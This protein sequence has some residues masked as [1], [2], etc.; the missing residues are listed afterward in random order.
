MNNIAPPTSGDD[1]PDARSG[2]EEESAHQSLGERPLGEPEASSARAASS[3]WFGMGWRILQSPLTN[4]VAPVITVLFIL[5]AAAIIRETFRDV[6]VIR[7]IGVP[8]SLADNG[9]TS[10]IV[11]QRLLDQIALINRQNEIASR[12]FLKKSR[13][14]YT[15]L[16]E[17]DM[18]LPGLG[19]S[20]RSVLSYLRSTVGESETEI[21]GEIIEQD[22]KR[23]VLRLRVSSQGGPFSD[24]VS[25][26]AAVGSAQGASS[27]DD[28]LRAGAIQAVRAL[29][30]YA[31][32][33]YYL[34]REQAKVP[35]IAQYCEDYDP[36]CKPWSA[37]LRGL[38]FSSKGDRN[39]A[40][41]SYQDALAEFH[42]PENGWPAYGM[43]Y[44][45]LADLKRTRS[46]RDDRQA[47]E[48]EYAEAMSM[49][50]KAIRLFEHHGLA[51]DDYDEFYIGHIYQMGYS[52]GPYNQ[53]DC[54]Q[55]AS[56]YRRAAAKG[57][58]LA[59]NSLGDLYNPDID[60]HNC[61]G[62]PEQSYGEAR[63]WYAQAAKGGQV[64]AQR[65]LGEMYKAGLGLHGTGEPELAIYYLRE[66]A[67][68][69]DAVALTHLGEIYQDGP[70]GM[71]DWI[72]AYAWFELAA[73]A[74]GETSALGKATSKRDA[75]GSHMTPEATAKAMS[76][77]H[78]WQLGHRGDL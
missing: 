46:V 6:V 53:P 12:P 39:G 3:R 22:D 58:A 48:R 21:G 61:A 38:V 70:G 45:Y 72:R 17:I 5:I 69:G 43:A 77:V 68:R 76:L 18:Q 36:S 67:E 26:G 75:A 56:W 31:L 1:L 30:S 51:T 59:Q 24:I 14:F 49:Y 52:V 50:A 41:V 7:P 66:A 33:V 4:L 20:L 78:D 32:A 42:I 47:N 54:A 2:R 60:K 34:G 71:P 74:Q 16:G 63:D 13:A 65:R 19:L 11:S 35:E 8:A 64:Y 37:L 23:L 10:T 44:A 62:L 9:Y 15:E 29:D 55:A 73:E 27:L 40:A 28:I 25:P 57:S